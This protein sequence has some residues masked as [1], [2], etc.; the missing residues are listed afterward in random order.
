MKKIFVIMA[1]AIALQACNN[2]NNNPGESG[3]VNDGIQA[4]D[5]NGALQDTGNYNNTPQT[6][7]AKGEHRTDLQQRD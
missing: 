4:V 5:T 6:D 2:S 1:T 7:T 3:T